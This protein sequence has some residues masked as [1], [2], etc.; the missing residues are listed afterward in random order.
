M[1]TKPATLFP[2]TAVIGSLTGASLLL[3]AAPAM[4]H[5]PFGGDAPANIVEG[6][7]SGMGHPVIGLDHLAFVIT[8]GLLAAVLNRGLWIPI[9]FVATSLLGTFGHLANVNLPAPEF[10]ISTSVL[11]FGLL[12]ALKQSLPAVVVI[13]LAAVAGVFHGYAYGEAVVGAGM[14]SL[15]AYLLGFSTIQLA[16]AIAGYLM[17]KKL[18]A[19]D[20]QTRLKLRFAGFTLTGVGAALLSGVILG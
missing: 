3:L 2:Q 8:A 13:A 12:L 18:G 7:L 1:P 15:L 5:H 4:A 11:V 9:A 6:F 14:P 20:E 16:I 10:F 19:S 17:A